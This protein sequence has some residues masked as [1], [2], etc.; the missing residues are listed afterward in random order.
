MPRKKRTRTG[1]RTPFYMGRDPLLDATPA[2][3]LDLHGQTRLQAETSLKNFLET[4]WRRDP[5]AVVHVVTGRGRGSPGRPVLRQAV[6]RML[7]STHASRID[8][9]A[10][11]LDEGGYMVRLRR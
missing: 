8:E 5:G 7:G 4:W 3:T 9:F 1:S 2:A 10:L 6:A 11:D